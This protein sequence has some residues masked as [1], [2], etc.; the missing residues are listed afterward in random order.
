MDRTGSGLSD[1]S[2]RRAQIAQYQF[3]FAGFVKKR[4]LG[5]IHH[6]LRI[7]FVLLFG[8]QLIE[9]ASRSDLG[10]DALVQE[11]ERIETV[12][13]RFVAS[14]R[15]FLPVMLLTGNGDDLE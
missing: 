9:R 10:Q 14:F 4:G 11:Y 13:Q 2:E 5:V 7:G 12:S 8:C 3:P 1:L 15:A 6:L